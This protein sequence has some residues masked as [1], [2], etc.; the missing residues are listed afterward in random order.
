MRGEQKDTTGP[1]ASEV[2]LLA[3]RKTVPYFVPT[4]DQYP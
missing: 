2:E 4:L 3:L 1:F